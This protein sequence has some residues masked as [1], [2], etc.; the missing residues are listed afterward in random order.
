VTILSHDPTGEPGT[1]PGG[2]RSTGRNLGRRPGMVSGRALGGALLIAAAAVVVFAAW[3][4]TTRRSGHPIVVAS[5]PLAAGS[6]LGPSDL[7]TVE[8]TLPAITLAHAYQSVAAVV[9]RTLAAP[10]GPGEVVQSSDLVPAGAN[11]PLRPVTISINAADA[12]SLAVGDLVDVVVT[13]GSAA[14]SPT[15]VVVRGARVMSVTAASGGLAGPDATA[16]V[17]IGVAD[18]SEVTAVV[19]AERTGSVDVVVGEPS[20]GAGLTPPGSLISP[21]SLPPSGTSS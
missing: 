21:D 14:S 7:R 1:R 16:T 11:P 17:T 6:I 8:A 9:G 13:N 2:G 5:H 10:L 20:D 19:H 3:L 12:S 15:D 18:L 4:G